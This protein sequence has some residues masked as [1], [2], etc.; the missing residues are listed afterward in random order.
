MEV[1]QPFAQEFVDTYKNMEIIKDGF[2]MSQVN[3]VVM[4]VGNMKQDDWS[5]V[6]QNLGTQGVELAGLLATKNEIET[7][8]TIP[9]VTKAGLGFPGIIIPIAAIIICLAGGIIALWG[10]L[11][12]N[13]FHTE[14]FPEN[15]TINGVDCSNMTPREANKALTEDWNSKDF[16]FL[17]NGSELGSIKL[18]DTTYKICKPLKSIRKDNFVKTAM[19]YYFHKPLN[20]SM[21]MPVKEPGTAFTEALKQAEYLKAK[22]PVETK[23]AYLDLTGNTAE[24]I[25]EVYGNTVNY[26]SLTNDICDLAELFKIFG[27]STRI[28]ILYSLLEKDMNVTEIAESL[29]M[30]QPAISQQLRV[31]KLN[32][33]VKFRR[34]GKSIIYSLADEHV[35]IILNIGLEHLGE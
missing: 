5:V 32:D 1:F 10:D 4:L 2:D 25:P 24:I 3:D 31:L 11:E 14:K 22:K 17:K 13:A 7:F 8:L 29:N 21:E 18:Q 15:T 27:D 12:A 35:K 6:L 34:D 23:N 30:T 19:S 26:N 28:K 9:L 33:L 16:T 20:L